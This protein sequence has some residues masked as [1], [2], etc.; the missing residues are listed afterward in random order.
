MNR[1]SLLFAVGR[2][3]AFGY[4]GS[5]PWPRLTHDMKH[6]KNTT[7]NKTVIMGRKTWESMPTLPNR[8]SIVVSQAYNCP[9]LEEAIEKSNGETYIIGGKSLIEEGSKHCGRIFVTLINADFEAD[10]Y[11][12]AKPI[13]DEFSYIVNM[14]QHADNGIMYQIQERIRPIYMFG[15]KLYPRF[16]KD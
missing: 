12:D 1:L 3:S 14:K 5:L 6:F 9:S 15:E 2:N 13:L 11:L 8:K 4:Q 10:V 7:V 16:D